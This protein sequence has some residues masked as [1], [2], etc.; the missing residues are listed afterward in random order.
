MTKMWMLSFTRNL[1][2]TNWKLYGFFKS[3]VR[4]DDI[5]KDIFKVEG[6]EKLWNMENKLFYKLLEGDLAI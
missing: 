3:Q 1:M 4:L 5:F 2:T 6:Q